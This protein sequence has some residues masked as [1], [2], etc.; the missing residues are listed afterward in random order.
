MRQPLL[1]ERKYMDIE[2]C[3]SY[4]ISSFTFHNVTNPQIIAGPVPA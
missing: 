4:C 2:S 1:P 3:T